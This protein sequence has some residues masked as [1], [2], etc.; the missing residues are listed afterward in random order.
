ML[1]LDAVSV[2]IIYI[3]NEKSNKFFKLFNFTVKVSQENFMGN[4]EN[5]QKRLNN[6]NY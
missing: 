3:K 2:Q 5:I 6:L 1:I 4:N